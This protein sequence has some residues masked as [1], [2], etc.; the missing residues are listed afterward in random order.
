MRVI[1]TILVIV[2]VILLLYGGVTFFIPRDVID[3]GDV[4]ITIRDNLVIPLPP[5]VGLVSLVVG[6]VMIMSA[7]VVIR[8]GA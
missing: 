1:G 3:L 7:P 6:I 5:L 8:P 2:G 4:S